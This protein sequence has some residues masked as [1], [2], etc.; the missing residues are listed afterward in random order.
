MERQGRPPD[1]Q[2]MYYSCA[3]D[4]EHRYAVAFMIKEV[5]KTKV[6]RCDRGLLAPTRRDSPN[7]RQQRSDIDLVGE[8]AVDHIVGNY[9]AWTT[10]M[11]KDKD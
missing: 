7:Y 10:K 9:G 5:I 11:K 3:E 2:R 8:G 1:N 6:L 4:A